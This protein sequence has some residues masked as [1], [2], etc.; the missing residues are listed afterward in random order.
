MRTTK[1]P[2]KKDM[3]YGFVKNVVTLLKQNITNQNAICVKTGMDA[4]EIAH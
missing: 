3:E 1:K 2:E 4:T